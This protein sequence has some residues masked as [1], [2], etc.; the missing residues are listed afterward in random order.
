MSYPTVLRSSLLKL[1]EK[2]KDN[3]EFVSPNTEEKAL[4]M[5]SFYRN[6]APYGHEFVTSPS[7]LSSEKYQVSLTRLEELLLKKIPR[8]RSKTKLKSYESEALTLAI[9]IFSSSFSIDP[10]T[11]RVQT[12]PLSCNDQS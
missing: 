3:A 7:F 8:S 12:R 5:Y 9:E 2:L 4:A 6:P 1:I 11:L 10:S